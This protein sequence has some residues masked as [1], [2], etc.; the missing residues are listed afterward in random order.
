MDNH[1]ELK[2]YHG[3][4]DPIMDMD[5]WGFDLEPIRGVT[6]LT[7]TNNHHI[8]VEFADADA[9]MVAQRITGWSEWDTNVLIMRLHDDLVEIRPMKD[10]PSY[11]GDWHLGTSTTKQ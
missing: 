5:D 8:R 9:C 11:F 4:K 3:R 10:T 2:L 6:G 1:L 7:V